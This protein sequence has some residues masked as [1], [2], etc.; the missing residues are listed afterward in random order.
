MR[1]CVMGL[2]AQA[3][4][5]VVLQGLFS[6]CDLQR[7]CC[8]G[9][10]AG[11]ICRGMP[12]TAWRLLRRLY[13]SLPA[14]TVRLHAAQKHLGSLPGLVNASLPSPMAMCCASVDPPAHLP[15]CHSY[16]LR[17]SEEGPSCLCV[18]FDRPTCLDM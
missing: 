8:L 5:L 17:S 18:D 6:S 3:Q 4:G 12:Y 2:Q 16:L 1:L 10:R 11:S 13:A 7:S 9:L 14:G 15:A